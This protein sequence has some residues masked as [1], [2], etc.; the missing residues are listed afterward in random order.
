[1]FFIKGNN[2]PNFRRIMA[3]ETYQ[4]PQNDNNYANN[5]WQRVGYFIPIQSDIDAGRYNKPDVNER[6]VNFD[7]L[8][9]AFEHDVSEAQTAFQDFLSKEIK[10][11][12][13]LCRFDELQAGAAPINDSDRKLL[14]RDREKLAKAKRL[15]R[16]KRLKSSRD[17]K[18]AEDSLKTHRTSEF[19]QKAK[20]SEI[21]EEGG[22]WQMVWANMPDFMS[23]EGFLPDRED[24]G[25]V[26]CELMNLLLT[27]SHQAD[28]EKVLALLT[29]LRNACPPEC[30]TVRHFINVVMMQLQKEVDRPDYRRRVCAFYAGYCLK[31]KHQRLLDACLKRHRRGELDEH[32]V[33]STRKKMN[34]AK[35]KIITGNDKYLSVGDLD[36]RKFLHIFHAVKFNR[37]PA[38]A[39]EASNQNSNNKNKNRPQNKGRDSGN[40]SRKNDKRE[41]DFDSVSL[42]TITVEPR[43]MIL[44]S[45]QNNLKEHLKIPEEIQKAYN[46]LTI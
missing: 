14:T 28:H 5:K 19:T 38:A 42:D 31:K 46:R 3:E 32:A 41:L 27:N 16:T 26:Y 21:F 1:M 34:A 10:A 7:Q 13:A 20:N 43:T 24:P 15:F 44:R 33:E 12:E 35:F 29:R 2:Y 4:T 22:Q 11:K 39:A 40:K 23:T 6:L 18:A 36:A 9:T 8:E 45:D 25:P 37:V 30:A 17:L